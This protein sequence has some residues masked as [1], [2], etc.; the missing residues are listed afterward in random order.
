MKAGWERRPRT[1]AGVRRHPTGD[2][3]LTA[4]L[5][6]N[7]VTDDDGSEWIEIPVMDTKTGETWCWARPL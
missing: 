5:Y 7:H 6:I 2:E 1:S 3:L 4:G